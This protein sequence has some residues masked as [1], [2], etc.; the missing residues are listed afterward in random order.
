M[1][2]VDEAAPSTQESDPYAI[3]TQVDIHMAFGAFYLMD[4][5]TQQAQAS[6]SNLALGIK[7]YPVTSS[8]RVSVENYVLKSSEENIIRDGKQMTPTSKRTLAFTNPCS[9]G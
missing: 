1:F 5:K 2:Q 4:G 7:L 8:F 3:L 6:L 9:F